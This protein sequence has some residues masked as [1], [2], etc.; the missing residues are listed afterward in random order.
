MKKLISLIFFAVSFHF[1][2]AQKSFDFRFW[3]DSLISLRE[4]VMIAPTE[5]ERMELNEDFMNLLE[6]I[7]LESN[8][9]K[10][11]WD[12]VKNFSVLTSPDKL[13]KIY[14]WYVIKDDYSVENFGFL[15]V[16][17][18]NRVK[19]VIYPLYDKK[20]VID[21]PKTSIG[22]HNRWYGAVY[23]K[24]ILL[25]AKNKNYYTL[26]GWNGNNIFSN[27]KII[28]VLHFKNDMTPIFGANVFK[29]YTE[30]V[31]RIIFDYAKE[32]SFHLSY[33]NHTYNIGNG[34]R[35]PK[36]KKVVYETA[37][38]EMIIFDQLIPLEAGLE[39]IP[40]FFVPESSLNQ[41]FIQDNGKWCF[42]KNV[43]GRNPDKPKPE[44]EIKTRTIYSP[45]K[46]R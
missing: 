46:S 41:G 6:S 31:N 24:I 35:D 30:K 10:F 19:Y 20:N 26:L 23:Y 8:S 9:F 22:N 44:Y 21:Y 27:Q 5:L 29:N 37:S 12:S 16:Y 7:L 45:I 38:G 28:E 4:D 15:Q 18:D 43:N 40:A 1:S 25:E 36:S 42:L 32:A 39:S 34:K 17:N 14:T 3:E 33:E 2:M 11:K 13:F